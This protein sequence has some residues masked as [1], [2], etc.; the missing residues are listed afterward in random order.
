METVSELLANHVVF[1]CVPERNG[2]LRVRVKYYINFDKQV[3]ENCY[4]KVQNTQ[5]PK[6]I[7]ELDRMFI[8]PAENVQA[9]RIKDG[10][11]YSVKNKKSIKIFQRSVSNE[12]TIY[13]SKEDEC[14][15]CLSNNANMVFYPCGHLICCS[16][17]TAKVD[18]CPLCRKFIDVKQQV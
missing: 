9:R 3:I 12:I 8:V 1:E 18:K 6:D 15:I 4:D 5:F 2:K 10:S 16:V 7:R 17:C 13:G 14:C 11:F